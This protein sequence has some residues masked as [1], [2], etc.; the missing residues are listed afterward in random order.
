MKI[1]DA[2]IIAQPSVG[3]FWLYVFRLKRNMD[4]HGHYNV[5]L[6]EG[7]LLICAHLADQGKRKEKNS[8]TL[9]DKSAIKTHKP[10][11][12]K[13]LRHINRHSKTVQPRGCSRLV[14]ITALIHFNLIFCLSFAISKTRKKLFQ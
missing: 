1:Q 3:F 4:L 7:R 14:M 8:K 2:L 5:L 12:H 6:K 11:T 13:L 9:H 10:K